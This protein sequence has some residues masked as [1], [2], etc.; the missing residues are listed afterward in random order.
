M[1][2]SVLPPLFFF[3][4]LL[5]LAGLAVYAAGIVLALL[6]ATLGFGDTVR[7]WNEAIVWFSGVLC[8]LGALLIALDLVLLLPAKRKQSRRKVFDTVLDRT[9]VVALTAYNDEQSIADAV[10]DFRSHPW[11]ALCWSSR[12]TAAIGRSIE[13]H[14]RARWS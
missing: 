7:S 4:T 3:G 5:G 8:S 14:G 13:Q 2:G 12:T 1:R 9:V 6:R 10:T 11:S